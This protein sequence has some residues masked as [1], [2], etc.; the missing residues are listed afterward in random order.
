MKNKLLSAFLFGLILVFFPSPLN[1]KAE[2]YTTFQEIN[3]DDDEITLMENWRSGFENAMLVHLPARHKMFGWDIYYEVKRKHFDYVAETLY[4][5]EN[6]GTKEVVHTYKYEGT[7]ENT[8]QRSVK[9][10]LELTGS[11][12]K[13]KFKFGLESEL[14]YSYEET[15]KSKSSETDSIKVTVA[16]KSTLK[17][18]VKGEGY[19]YQGV[20]QKFFFWILSKKGAFEYVI[21]STEY[22]SINIWE[23]GNE[24][25]NGES[26]NN[27]DSQDIQYDDRDLE[28]QEQ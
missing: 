20:A 26:T 25:N 10:S 22:Y 9:G 8:I 19:I 3:F 7:E 21:I 1:T 6:K 17:I 16:P 27:G 13:D 4:Y 24:E 28:D 18:E 5:I 2:S 15:V 14:E 12:S 23:N 11:G